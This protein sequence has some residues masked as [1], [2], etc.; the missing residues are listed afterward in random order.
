[1]EKCGFGKKETELT[2]G[3]AFDGTLESY[4]K[5]SEKLREIIKDKD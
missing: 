2:G 3:L 1:M 5:L 4:R